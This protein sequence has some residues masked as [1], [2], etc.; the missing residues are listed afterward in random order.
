[1]FLWARAALLLSVL[2]LGACA[3]VEEIESDTPSGAPIGEGFTN[4]AAREGQYE[5]DSDVCWQSID[6]SSA[7]QAAVQQA[8]EACMLQ[9]GWSRTP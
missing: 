1:M 2:V 5:L 3:T 4:P 9:K 7:T 6:A 8:Y